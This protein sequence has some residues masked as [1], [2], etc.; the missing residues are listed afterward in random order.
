LHLVHSLGSEILWLCGRS[1]RFLVSFFA[2]LASWAL[3]SI[4]SSRASPPSAAFLFC[5]RQLRGLAPGLDFPLN[6]VRFDWEAATCCSSAWI[7]LLR[8]RRGDR[9]RLRFLIP[10]PCASDLTQIRFRFPRT[11]TRSQRHL[12]LLFLAPSRFFPGQTLLFNL[13]FAE[14]AGLVLVLLSPPAS[15]ASLDLRFVVG[16][17]SRDRSC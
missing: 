7:Q 3:C 9:P 10:A 11:R 5:P 12:G 1:V 4:L 6:F 17:V 13:H 15:V 16:F 2:Q 14:P 8:P